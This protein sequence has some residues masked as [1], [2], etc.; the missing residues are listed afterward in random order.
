[1][2]HA[3][4]ASVATPAAAAEQDKPAELEYEGIVTRT[5][6]F[7]IDA[8]II[9]LVAVIV[10]AIVALVLSVLHLPSELDPVLVAVGGAAYVLWTIAYFVTFWSSTGQTPGNRIMRIQVLVA[11]T[12]KPPKPWRSIIRLGGLVLAALPLFLG[13]FPILVTDRRRGLQDMLAGTVVVAAPDDP[14][15]VVSGRAP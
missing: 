2:T 10:A 12:A 8:G 4:R 3:V 6:A 13:F 14:P 1:V 5:I 11:E 9:N 15:P 7:G